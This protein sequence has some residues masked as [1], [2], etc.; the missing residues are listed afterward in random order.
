MLASHR[1]LAE[2]GESRRPEAGSKPSSPRSL[3]IG[4]CE[5]E[6]EILPQVF[7]RAPHDDQVLPR[8]GL[9]SDV[10]RDQEFLVEAQPL[11]DAVRTHLR[12]HES[13]DNPVDPEL[14]APSVDWLNPDFD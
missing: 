1:P 10:L 2:G 12:T 4:V 13:C 8:T 14:L 5:L 6:L 3:E 9:V 7:E 11:E